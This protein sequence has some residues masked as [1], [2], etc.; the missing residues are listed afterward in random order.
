LVLGNKKKDTRFS[1]DYHQLVADFLDI[2]PLDP[3]LELLSKTAL[4]GLIRTFGFP[5]QITLQVTYRCLAFIR[6]KGQSRAGY[7]VHIEKGASL[8][9][10]VDSILI[11]DDLKKSPKKSLFMMI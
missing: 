10:A 6:D 3:T 1:K 2:M 9:I 4:L 11:A 5:R 8:L 7:Y